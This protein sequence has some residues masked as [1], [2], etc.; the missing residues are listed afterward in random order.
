VSGYLKGEGAREKMCM[1]VR[2]GGERKK[3]RKKER[4]RK[5]ER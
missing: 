2:E 3:E 4:V 5:R 1:F